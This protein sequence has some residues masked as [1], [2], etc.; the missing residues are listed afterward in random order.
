MIKRRFHLSPFLYGLLIGIM[1]VLIPVSFV[2]ANQQR[3]HF[4]IGGEAFLLVCLIMTI[5][6]REQTIKS[7]AKATRDY[8][9][10]QRNKILIRLTYGRS[11]L[12]KQK[13]RNAKFVNRT[14]CST[15]NYPQEHQEN[16]NLSC[17]S[18]A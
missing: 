6:W 16:S 14:A 17:R 2:Y 4:G 12:P 10:Q 13:R 7:K 18:V 11:Y 5:V 8:F 9:K 15:W 3:G 1:V